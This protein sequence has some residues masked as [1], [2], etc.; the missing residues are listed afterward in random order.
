MTQ[1]VTKRKRR[2]TVDQKYNRLSRRVVRRL[3]VTAAETRWLWNEASGVQVGGQPYPATSKPF[4]HT[5]R[6]L[7]VLNH[8]HSAMM[9]HLNAGHRYDVVKLAWVDASGSVVSA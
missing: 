5:P 1:R 4:R 6:E 3:A 2:E 8:A 9:V 7:S